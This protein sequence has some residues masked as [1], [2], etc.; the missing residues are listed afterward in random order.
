MTKAD[1]GPML[2]AVLDMGRILVGFLEVVGFD[3]PPMQDKTSSVL[4]TKLV[5][6]VGCIYKARILIIYRACDS[7]IS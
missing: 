1:I 7:I 4:V 6:E 3:N 5:S 2:R